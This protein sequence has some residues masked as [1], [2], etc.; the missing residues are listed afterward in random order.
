MQAA[1]PLLAGTLLAGTL[2]AG[3][4]QDP[5]QDKL[6]KYVRD[7][8]GTNPMIRMQASRRVVKGGARG[9][10]ACQRFIAANN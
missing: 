10:A 6:D 7:A 1:L 5:S 8:C 2:L 4:L 9:L 3:T